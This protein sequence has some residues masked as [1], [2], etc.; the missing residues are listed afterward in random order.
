MTAMPCTRCFHIVGEHLFCSEHGGDPGWSEG[1]YKLKP[2]NID[3]PPMPE[4]I[5]DSWF[6]FINAVSI[7]EP[8]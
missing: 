4:N 7:E 5:Y 6:D 1:A 3:L 2:K 8:P